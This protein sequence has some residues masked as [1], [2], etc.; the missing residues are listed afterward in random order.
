MLNLDKIL[1]WIS[2][3]NLRIVL[4]MMLFAFISYF[5]L[6]LG[7]YSIPAA[8]HP[9]PLLLALLSGFVLS[10]IIGLGSY[11]TLKLRRDLNGY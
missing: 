2:K 10:P 6:V 9:N 1:D 5:L 3:T 8:N 7:L 4:F 11:L